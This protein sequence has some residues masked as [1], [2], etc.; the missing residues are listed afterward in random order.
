MNEDRGAKTCQNQVD[1]VV[2]WRILSEW[3][4]TEEAEVTLLG[5]GGLFCTHCL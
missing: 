2:R 4:L 5:S 1:G 3:F